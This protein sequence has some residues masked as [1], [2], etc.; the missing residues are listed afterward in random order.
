VTKVLALA[1]VLAAA[2]LAGSAYASH[3]RSD[4]DFVI[5]SGKTLVERFRF[6][7]FAA[8][9]ALREEAEGEATFVSRGARRKIELRITCLRVRRNRATIGGIVTTGSPVTSPPRP[10]GVIFV[11]ED[12]GGE[13]DRMSRLVKEPQ[14]P[15]VCPPPSSLP[16]EFRLRE[17]DIVVHD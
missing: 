13:R 16:L 17:G 1:L 5:G 15:A 9:G 12:N 8:S 11:V 7:A 4:P 6:G 10:A 2:G 3:R 14:R